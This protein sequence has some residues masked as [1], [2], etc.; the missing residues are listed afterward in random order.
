MLLS[1]LP[2]DFYLPAA[3]HAAR[4]LLGARLVRRV[5]GHERAGLIIE[6]EAY[7]NESDLACHARAGRTP[8][9]EVM[10]G[11]PGRAYVYFIYGM[12]WM[13]NIVTGPEG[14]PAAVLVRAVWP[15]FAR[16]KTAAQKKEWIEGPARVCRAFQIDGKLNGIDL[17]DPASGLIVTP[18]ERVPDDWVITG[19]RVGIGS[20]PEPWRSQPWRYQVDM[21]RWRPT[22]KGWME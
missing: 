22:L 16:E 17:T 2:P 4:A 10:Y 13:F 12:H 7:L 8:R 11:P 9:T 19:P 15:L 3:T 18:G 1:P 14:Q 20:V 6:T 5:D 21:S